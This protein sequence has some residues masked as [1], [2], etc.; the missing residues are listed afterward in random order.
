MNKLFSFTDFA[1]ALYENVIEID[2]TIQTSRPASL[3]Y[4]LIKDKFG[5]QENIDDF[6]LT[7]N[8][9]V[10]ED[11]MKE[12]GIGNKDIPRDKVNDIRKKGGG[13]I[14][15]NNVM[16]YY[17][18]KTKTMVNFLYSKKS[19]EMAKLVNDKMDKV[20]VIIESYKK[21]GKLSIGVKDGLALTK[22]ILD[23]IDFSDLKPYTRAAGLKDSEVKDIIYNT[24]KEKNGT[25][26]GL[27]VKG[28]LNFLNF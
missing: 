12:I 7:R 6:L 28:A 14:Y 25:A 17:D 3:I 13:K 19:D 2:S 21:N 11:S 24:V 16:P 10:I 8:R 4:N 26:V 27:A 15:L 9:A 1:N 22:E 18:A 5:A 23:K 20:N